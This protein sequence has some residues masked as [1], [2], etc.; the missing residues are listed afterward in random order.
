MY[1]ALRLIYLLVNRNIEPWRIWPS[2][3][4]TSPLAI[5]SHGARLAYKVCCLRY[6]CRRGV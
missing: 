4:D 5:S 3:F 2:L 1:V 6:T